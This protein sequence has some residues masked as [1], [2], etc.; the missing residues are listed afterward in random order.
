MHIFK[1]KILKIIIFDPDLKVT[2]KIEYTKII[3]MQWNDE[4]ESRN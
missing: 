3:Y 2:N 4:E 1:R